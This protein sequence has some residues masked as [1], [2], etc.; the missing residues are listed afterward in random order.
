MDHSIGIVVLDALTGQCRSNGGTGA[1][2]RRAGV[3]KRAWR[4]VHGAVSHD[5]AGLAGSLGV[6]LQKRRMRRAI[7]S[8]LFQRSTQG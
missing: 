7:R 5:H 1:A 2:R 6:P 8:V 3:P 4:A